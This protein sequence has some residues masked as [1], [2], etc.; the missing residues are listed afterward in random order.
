MYFKNIFTRFIFR[1]SFISRVKMR[2]KR[3]KRKITKNEYDDLEFLYK[4]INREPS[5]VFDCGANIGFVTH[6]FNKRFKNAEIYSF[7]PNPKVFEELQKSTKD[8]NDIHIYNYGISNEKDELIFYKNNNTGTSSF[9]EPND[10]HRANLA[11]KYEKIKIPVIS[12]RDF[13]GANKIE[14]I[15]ILKLDI[16]GFELKALQGCEDMLKAEKIDF[17]YSEVNLVPTYDGQCLI[18]EVVSFLRQNN[19][20]PYNFYGYNE[21]SLRSSFITN[22][23]FVS[24]KMAKELVEKTGEKAI[25]TNK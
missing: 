5:I 11:R 7:E 25:Y 2:L 24:N 8:D 19:Y 3:E 13:C 6:Q 23:L 20:I 10:F 1:K 18:E 21:T 16:E 14:K 22:I 12:L 15:D 17:I 9:L 4:K